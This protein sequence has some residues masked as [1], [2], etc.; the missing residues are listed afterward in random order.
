MILLNEIVICGGISS[1]LGD[2]YVDPKENKNNFYI[3]AKNLYSHSM[4]QSLPF[5]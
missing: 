3:D 5:N 2:G 4:G 1:V